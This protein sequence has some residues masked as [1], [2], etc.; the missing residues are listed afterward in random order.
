MSPV[1]K[2]TKY[3]QSAAPANPNLNT[4]TSIQ[5]NSNANAGGLIKQLANPAD[6]KTRAAA[7]DRLC[8]W[9]V[10]NDV[11]Y[12]LIDVMKLWR[13]LYYMYWHADGFQLQRELAKNIAD[14]QTKFTA[15]DAG[16]NRCLLYIQSSLSVLSTEWPLV[17]RLRLDKFMY[18]VRCIVN[19]SFQVLQ[20]HN[21]D[22]HKIHE[23]LGL[24]SSCILCVPR[25]RSVRGLQLYII[26]VYLTELNKV[27]QQNNQ[28]LPSTTQIVELLT[29][30]FDM[31]MVT[32]QDNVIIQRIKTEVITPLCNDDNT[33]YQLIQQCLNKQHHKLA[34]T[35][36]AVHKTPNVAA[37]HRHALLDIIDELNSASDQSNGNLITNADDN[38]Q[39]QWT[40]DDGVQLQV[41]IDNEQHNDDEDDVIAPVDD[42]HSNIV[43]DDDEHPFAHQ[44][45]K[46]TR[47]SKLKKSSNHT[48]QYDVKAK[49]RKSVNIR[50]SNNTFH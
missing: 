31:L 25:I 17:D 41:A 28:S 11:D 26:D 1:N 23:L 15:E 10:H 19:A 14:V 29:P 36:Q 30:L 3:N 4:D 21:Y 16:F 46:S 48:I 43:S 38:N 5:S 35:L 7:F 9:L 45:V 50:T 6:N 40:N 33:Q 27:L 12:S 32:N 13:S 39:Q 8:N 22:M 24:Y 2:K 44:A 20:I 18:M 49:R 42:L 47:T 34:S 37:G